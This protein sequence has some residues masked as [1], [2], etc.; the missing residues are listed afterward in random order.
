MKASRQLNRTIIRLLGTVVLSF[1]FLICGAFLFTSE[2]LGNYGNEV[3]LEA[4][5][6]RAMFDISF[7][8]CICAGVGILLLNTKIFK[9]G[10]DY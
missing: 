9:D 2:T 6:Q 7:V 10:K 3:S 8:V 4:I 1:I 5:K